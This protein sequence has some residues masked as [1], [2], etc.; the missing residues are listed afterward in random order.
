MGHAEED[1]VVPPVREVRHPRL[2]GV[3]RETQPVQ[4]AAH[5][6]RSA[7]GRRIEGLMDHRAEVLLAHAV[8]WRRLPGIG[9][10]GVVEMFDAMRR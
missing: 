4:H 8:E 2:V 10:A 7:V 1:E 3:K 6:V 9:L 5:L